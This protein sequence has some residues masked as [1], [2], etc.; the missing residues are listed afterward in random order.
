MISCPEKEICLF[1][2]FDAD[3][4][5]YWSATGRADTKIAVPFIDIVNNFRDYRNLAYAG[6]VFGRHDASIL[7]MVQ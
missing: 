1:R 7:G 2:G 5:K 4:Q 6:G 3:W